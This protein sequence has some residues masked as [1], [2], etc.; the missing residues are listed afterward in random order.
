MEDNENG[1]VLK[2][3]VCG[4]IP[5]S[6][7]RRCGKC[8]G[9]IKIQCNECGHLSEWGRHY[10]EKCGNPLPMTPDL[11]EQPPKPV[12][13]PEQEHSSETK[14]KKPIKL[15][16][17][18][19]QDAVIEHDASFRMKLE[20]LQ[21]QEKKRI[22]EEQS[23][24]MGIYKGR[25][26]K[27]EAPAPQKAF[28]S[29]KPQQP[30]LPKADPQKQQKEE[31]E[32][33]AK[34]AE[35][36]K[37]EEAAK[38]DTEK[39][40]ANNRIDSAESK[41]SSKKLALYGGIIGGVCLLAFAVYFF[42]IRPYMPK[43]QLM[44]AAKDYLSAFTR[45]NYEEA[46]QMLSTNSKM[47]CPVEDY[48]LYNK[49]AFKGTREF[50]NI[51]VHSMEANHALVKYQVRDADGNWVYDYTSFVKEQ[52]KWTRPYAWTLYQP[53]DDALARKDT[54]QAMFLAQK[55]IITDPA[56]PRSMLYMCKAAYNAALY[57]Q[58]SE[59]CSDMLQSIEG[60]PVKMT[61][62][63][64]DEAMIY[65]ADSLVR[66][67][68]SRAALDAFDRLEERAT[69]TADQNCYF[70]LNRAG[71]YLDINDMEKAKSDIQL[72]IGICPNGENKS[73]AVSVLSYI[74]GKGGPDAI[75]FAKKSRIRE[76]LPDVET[77]R[78]RILKD[79]AAKLGSKARKYASK[80]KWNAKYA[81]GAKYKVTL[82]NEYYDFNIGDQ[83]Q[84]DV[85][86]VNV[87]LFKNTGNIEKQ[88]PLPEGFH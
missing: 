42:F 44:M 82:T 52:G 75:Q 59:A 88:F 51:E 14:P 6:P 78:S 45:G 62:A 76:D 81:G 2:C 36:A 19:F 57:D 43:L 58:A 16:I 71:L 63:E 13:K 4:N 54:N 66:Q 35:K 64:V 86:I 3:N 68:R 22:Q 77:L 11:P 47:I 7:S 28:F 50:K 31:K 12:A 9:T 24:G 65:L 46:Y 1:L 23:S 17:E 25:E 10:C 61:P 87:D 5:T 56:D 83:A 33:K 8:G 80:D 85:F 55:L 38:K 20:D 79:E 53:I 69:L 73:K 26:D 29:T 67:N 60:Y 49:D 27:P 40:E 18:T 34:E 74:N 32:L 30:T 21:A 70:R 15:E 41:E 84:K 37:K 48:I 72:A 39:K